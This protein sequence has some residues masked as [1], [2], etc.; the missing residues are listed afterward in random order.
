MASTQV[1]SPMDSTVKTKD[2]ERKLQIYG[3]ILALQAGKIPSNNQIDIALNSFLASKA[4]VNPSPEISPLGHDLIDDVR[5]VMEQ[6]KLLILTK[7]KGD[8][9]QNF[10]W[11]SQCVQISKDSDLEAP[12]D[13]ESAKQHGQK[14]LD[15]FRTL[16]MLIIS[17]GQFRK[18]CKCCMILS[19]VI[20]C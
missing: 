12:V 17:N 16:G 9:I 6:S 1:N 14:A 15:G 2:V 11:Q 20:G 4:L 19:W 8:L 18:L 10:I 7:N 3:I 13:K 5:N